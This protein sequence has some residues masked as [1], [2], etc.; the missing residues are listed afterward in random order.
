MRFGICALRGAKQYRRSQNNELRDETARLKKQIACLQRKLGVHNDTLEGGQHIGHSPETFLQS[1]GSSSSLPVWPLA[2]L[3]TNDHPILSQNF[4]PQSLPGFVLTTF[5]LRDYNF[6]DEFD[7]W[8]Q[9]DGSSNRSLNQLIGHEVSTSSSLNELPSMEETRSIIRSLLE[10]AKHGPSNLDKIIGQTQLEEDCRLVYGPDGLMALEYANNRFR[11]FITV[12]LAMCMAA[13][14]NGEDVTTDARATACRAIGMK[15]LASVTSREDLAC[16]EAL[17][18]L[19][20]L[21]IHEPNGSSLW[22]LVGLTGRT[23]IAISLHRRDDIYLPTVY[24]SWPAV[25]EEPATISARNQR[26]KDLF[27]AFY[28][29]DRLTMFTLN[30]PASIKDEDIDVELPPL[31]MWPEGKYATASS[32]ALWVHHLQA[33]RLYGQI[34]ESLYGVSRPNERDTTAQ[35]EKVVAKY[36]HQVRQWYMW[37]RFNATVVPFSDDSVKR[38]LLDDVQYH[39]M[40][41]ALHQPSP[42]IPS[43]SSTF[44]AT[45]KRSASLS[46]N[47][48]HHAAFRKQLNVH[49]V[50]LYHFFISCAI[51][52][53]CFH[54]YEIRSDLVTVPHDEVTEMLARC[55]DTLPLFRGSGASLVR[56]YG[57]MLTEIIRAFELL[58]QQQEEVISVEQIPSPTH[59]EPASGQPQLDPSQGSAF[60]IDMIVNSLLQEGYIPNKTPS[61]IFAEGN[62]SSEL[63]NFMLP[64]MW[65][66]TMGQSAWGSTVERHSNME[67]EGEEGPVCG[68][69]LPS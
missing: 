32:E 8:D 41:M 22:Q 46:V 51:L 54:Q 59:V 28:S 57:A 14:V 13:A 16:V 40:M 33:R 60:D 24:P 4:R 7:D 25:D 15:E 65:P 34:Y 50:N 19:C 52:I 68:L 31:T 55:R 36:V 45:L 27:W 47:V 69:G 56:R 53:Y 6:S 18:L 39:Q 66:D 2:L 64:G 21:A 3:A 49:W 10:S 30:R 11:C 61:P 48:F 62:M 38:H 1:S 5:G 9:D 29:L 44:M 17:T 42:L 43:V 35:R 67:T 12:Y 58:Q 63:A 20:E 26:R 37:S 23:A